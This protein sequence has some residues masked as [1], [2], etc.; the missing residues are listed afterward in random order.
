MNE[1]EPAQLS[2]RVVAVT[3]E[4][5]LLVDVGAIRLASDVQALTSVS[6]CVKTGWSTVEY[7]EFSIP[8]GCETVT[9]S[10]MSCDRCQ[11]M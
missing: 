1:V 8:G 11:V 4:E 6:S 5:L 7:R 3:D 10:N 9:K 2:N